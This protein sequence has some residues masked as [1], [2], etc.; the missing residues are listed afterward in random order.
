MKLAQNK[1]VV[2]LLMLVTF[3]G[4]AMAYT[5]TPCAHSIADADMPMMNHAKMMSVSMDKNHQQENAPE[6]NMDCCQEQ[7]QCPMSGCVSLSVLV[8]NSFNHSISAEQKI[9]QLPSLHQSQIN[10]FLYRPPIS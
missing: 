7:C 5:A 10:S 2:V 9:V 4:Q 8:N 6:T 3:M 1:I